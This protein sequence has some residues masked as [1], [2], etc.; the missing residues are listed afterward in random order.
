[1]Q[2]ATLKDGNVTLYFTKLKEYEFTVGVLTKVRQDGVKVQCCMPGTEIAMDST[3]QPLISD[4]EISFPVKI[5]VLR[6]QYKNML[7]NSEWQWYWELPET[8][9]KKIL[10]LP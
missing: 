4:K 10:G 7:P 5:L 8:K 1:M 3:R 2:K 9:V 6:T